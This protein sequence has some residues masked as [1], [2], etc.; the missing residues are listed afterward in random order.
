MSENADGDPEKVL[1][2]CKEKWVT[3]RST[4]DDLTFCA[5]ARIDSNECFD[6]EIDWATAVDYCKS[7]N[8]KPCATYACPTKDSIE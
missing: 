6:N 3:N 4:D 5:L 7:H 8:N 2:D 1:A